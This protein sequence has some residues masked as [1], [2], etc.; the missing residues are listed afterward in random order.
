MYFDFATSQDGSARLARSLAAVDE[1]NSFVGKNRA[2]TKWWAIHLD[3]PETST[4]F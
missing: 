3:T 4:P 1:K 2:A